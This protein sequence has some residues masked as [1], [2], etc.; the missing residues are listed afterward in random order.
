MQQIEAE[1]AAILKAFPGIGHTSRSTPGAR[2]PTRRKRRTMSASAKKAMS[3]GMRKYWA[4]R[5]KQEAQEGK[6]E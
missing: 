6:A 3:E 4:K 1:R 5:K 2:I